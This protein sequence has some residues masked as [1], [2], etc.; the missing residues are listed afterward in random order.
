M[1]LFAF[2]QVNCFSYPITTENTEQLSIAQVYDN[3][4]DPIRDNVEYQRTKPNGIKSGKLY[5]PFLVFV[6]N[7]FQSIGGMLVI[8]DSPC[9]SAHYERAHDTH[10][11]V[12]A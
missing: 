1:I 4:L 7:S 3:F 9:A 12:K 8:K 6:L 11:L 5:L 2:S 10:A